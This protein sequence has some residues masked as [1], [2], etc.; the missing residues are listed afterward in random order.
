M[1]NFL[2]SPLKNMK[3]SS[4][5]LLVGLVFSFFVFLL[6]LYLRGDYPA[7]MEHVYFLFSI[8]V[9][10]L[11]RDRFLLC[12]VGILLLSVGFAVPAV[13]LFSFDELHWYMDSFLTLLF[14]LLIRKM[15]IIEMSKKNRGNNGSK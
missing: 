15:T 4:R 8:L 5:Y 9:V 13:V 3:K 12:I 7:V 2:K 11:F 6:F 14:I 1:L 10:L